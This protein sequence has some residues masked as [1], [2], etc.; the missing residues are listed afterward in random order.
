MTQMNMFEVLP[1]T[2]VEVVTLNMPKDMIE[3]ELT[4]FAPNL[5]VVASLMT[6]DGYLLVL[7]GYV[8]E[9]QNIINHW[10]KDAL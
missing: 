3:W 1:E 6:E 9:L 8:A 10:G 7:E 4:C 2:D 5:R